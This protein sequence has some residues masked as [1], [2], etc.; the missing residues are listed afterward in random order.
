MWVKMKWPQGLLTR[1]RQTGVQRASCLLEWNREGC[2]GGCTV[3]PHWTLQSQAAG[4]P[5]K[6]GQL[7]AH[8]RWPPAS[9]RARALDKGKEE[10]AG[11]EERIR[12]RERESKP[13]ALAGFL[14]THTCICTD[15]H[16][17]GEAPRLQINIIN[18]EST[19]YC[20]CTHS[21]YCT[22]ASLWV[23]TLC[24]GGAGGG[25][26]GLQPWRPE[27]TAPSSL[28]HRRTDSNRCGGQ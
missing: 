1:E 7:A 28:P 3:G 11:A 10:R 26:G 8:C 9:L 13:S 2:S 17:G 19:L 20:T 21:P 16:A 5:G 12:E 4:A 6:L 23:Y 22:P 27:G 14:K 25:G 24:K 18:G 15:T